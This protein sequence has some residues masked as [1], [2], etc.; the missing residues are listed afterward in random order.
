MDLKGKNLQ[1]EKELNALQNKL[2]ESEHRLALSNQQIDKLKVELQK[3]LEFNSKSISRI[4]SI[5]N[6]GAERETLY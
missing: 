3:L 4:E 5:E 1:L 6:F 2:R